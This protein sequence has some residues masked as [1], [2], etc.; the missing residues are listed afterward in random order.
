MKANTIQWVKYICVG[1]LLTYMALKSC[2]AKPTRRVH[3]PSVA[4]VSFKTIA[5]WHGKFT[6]RKEQ[7]LNHLYNGKD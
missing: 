6:G 5:D 4:S 2:E 1:V 3:T 7:Y